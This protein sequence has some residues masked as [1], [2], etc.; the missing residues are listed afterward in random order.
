MVQAASEAILTMPYSVPGRLV[1]G[2]SAEITGT[3][4]IAV[5]AAGGAGIKNYITACTITNGHATVGT[6]VILKNGSTALW[7]C[8]MPAIDEG[9]NGTVHLVFPT[10]IVT[11]ANTA[12]N[13]ANVSDSGST[14]VSATGYRAA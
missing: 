14:F 2:L 3:T 10:P 9:G 5:I 11:A 8:Y 12:F 7:E 1:S 6:L 13:A 4:D